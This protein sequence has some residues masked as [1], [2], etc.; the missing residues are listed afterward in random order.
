[1]TDTEQQPEPEAQAGPGDG[2][3]GGEPDVEQPA[4][5]VSTPTAASF[6]VLHTNPSGHEFATRVAADNEDHAR[7]RV[8]TAHE[9]NT[10][11]GVVPDDGRTEH[12]SGGKLLPVVNLDEE[13]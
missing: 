1:M 2:G 4:A 5:D 11:D 3:P 7:Q 6:I 10:I 13:P 9:D 8:T 12:G